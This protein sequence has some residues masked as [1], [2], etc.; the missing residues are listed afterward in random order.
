MAAYDIAVIGAGL[1]GSAAARHLAADF[2]DL[3]LCVIGPDEPND[4]KAHDGVFSSHYDQGRI[5][6]VLD[7]NPLWA[8]LASDAIAAYPQIE[9]E[10]GIVFHHRAGCLRAT[11][12]PERIAEIDACAQD[13]APAHER[14][15]AAGCARRYPFLRFSAGFT[16]WDEGGAAGYI[17]PRSLVGAQLTIAEVGGATV[18]RAIVE[19]LRRQGE[20]WEIQTRSSQRIH[21]R[22]LLLTAGGYANTLLRRKLDLR[23]KAHTILLAEVAAAEI[24]RLRGMPSVIATFADEAVASLYMLPPVPYP[25][26]KT[27]IKLGASGRPHELPTPEHFLNARSDD[28][29]LLDWFRSDGRADVAEALKAALHAMLPGLKALS[30][31][32]VPCLIS[33]SAH[34]NPYV[35]RLG[36][37]LYVATGGNGAAAKSSDAIGRLGAELCATGEWRSDLPREAFRAVYSPAD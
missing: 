24:E 7:P 30:H 19:R 35:D 21:A 17:N 14:L 25:D 11:D 32:S 36:E 33:N 23:T 2:P 16:A 22:K 27:Y 10:S 6:R 18:I 1:I 9:A 37:G 3:K 26:G 8:R 4:R 5:T 31:H 29:E 13:F 28:R 20:S 34:G 15:G 12:I